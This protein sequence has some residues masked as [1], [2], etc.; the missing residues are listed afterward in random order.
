V[1][2]F[3]RTL[4]RRAQLIGVLA[5]VT[6][7]LGV[8][9]AYAYPPGKSLAVGAVRIASGDKKV[10]TFS[11]TATNVQPGCTVSFRLEGG[12]RGSAQAGQ[13][14]TATIELSAPAKGGKAEITAKTVDC[15]SRER[16]ETDVRLNRAHLEGP[17]HCKRKKACEIRAEHYPPDS[18]VTFTAV[19]GA[20]T[21]V[22]RART[23]GAGR[24][25]VTFQFPDKYAWAIVGAVG[26]EAHTWWVQVD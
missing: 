18:D 7:G 24:A 17:E 20:T 6:A 19:R 4:R 16:A 21:I 12:T 15:A 11:V 23:D 14:G 9:A 3:V 26:G 13:D 5:A 2:P 10:A 1:S 22:R 8:S 25:S